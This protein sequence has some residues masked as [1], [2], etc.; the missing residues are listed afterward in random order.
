MHSRPIGGRLL[1]LS[2]A[3]FYIHQRIAAGLLI[4]HRR[5]DNHIF[6]HSLRLFQNIS[7]PLQGNTFGAC[8]FDIGKD[9]AHLVQKGLDVLFDGLPKPLIAILQIL[10]L[11]CCIAILLNM[12]YKHK[13]GPFSLENG[14]FLII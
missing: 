13:N 11:D 3:L 12:L 10:K 9:C 5:I 4:I 14:P 8:R 2:E 6:K 1:Y 7:H